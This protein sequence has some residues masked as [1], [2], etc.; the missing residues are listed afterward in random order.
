QSGPHSRTAAS[1]S[2][3]VQRLLG[4]YGV[5]T[6]GGDGKGYDIIIISNSTIM[7]T[8]DIQKYIFIYVK[9]KR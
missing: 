8:T 4:G 9:V 7:I 1:D 2:R 5:Y 3:V 6:E